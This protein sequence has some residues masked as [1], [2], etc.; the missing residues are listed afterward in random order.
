MPPFQTKKSN[1]GPVFMDDNG[2]IVSTL[3]EE[4]PKVTEKI[5][6]L[7]KSKTTTMEKVF[8]EEKHNNSENIQKLHINENGNQILYTIKEGENISY[9][10]SNN[11]SNN[12]KKTKKEFNELADLLV[13]KSKNISNIKNETFELDLFKGGDKEDI[14]IIDHDKN[15]K[16]SKLFKEELENNDVQVDDTDLL[17]LMDKALELN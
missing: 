11:Y 9:L 16:Y 17:E 1:A 4:K 8:D 6:D 2:K 5:S 15:N 13:T 12:V 10:D 3:N 7:E 14:I